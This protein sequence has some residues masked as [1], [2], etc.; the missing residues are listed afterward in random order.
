MNKVKRNFNLIILLLVLT[1]ILFIVFNTYDLNSKTSENEYSRLISNLYTDTTDFTLWLNNK[2]E[3]VNTAKDFV[4]NFAYGELTRWNT[5]NPYLNI[6]NDDPDISQIYIG[7]ATGHFITGG[8]WIP[9]D[10]YDPRTRVWYMAAVEANETIIS[11]VY[12]D[13]ETGDRTV[14]ISSPL[15]LNDSFVG[16]I[17]A[18]IFMNDINDWLKN[19]VSGEDVYT[20]LMDPEGTIIVHTLRP[21]LVGKNFYRDKQLFDSYIPRMDLFLEY[22]EEAKDTSQVVRMEYVIDD[23]KTKGIIRRIEDG[24]WYLAVA[25]IEHYDI[26]K[27]ISLNGRSIIFNLLMLA[28]VFVLLYLVIRI[29]IVLVERNQLLTIDSERDFL[30]GI[31]NRRYFDLYMQKLW[32]SAEDYPE[33]SLFMMDIDHFKGYNDTYGHIKGDEVLVSVTEIINRTIRKQ[34]VFVRYG[35]EEFVLVLDEVSLENAKKIAGKIIAAV[36]EYDIENSSSPIGRISISIGIA[37]MKQGLKVGARQFTDKADQALYKAKA[38][39]RN[40]F[41][42]YSDDS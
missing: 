11:D 3:V 2:K 8:E 12:I 33:S 36:Y 19:E 6:N 9:P 27:F 40:T 10:D 37:M 17:S 18:D 31:F 38:K 30:T 22:F 35:G 25:A 34:D 1:L 4:D 21:E 20:Y 13:R 23:H 42:V 16:V 15:H 41:S 29:K 7:L 32:I 39:G 24:D 14:T 26:R 28:V 5:L